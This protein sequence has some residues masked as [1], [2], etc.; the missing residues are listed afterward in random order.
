[1]FTKALSG[2]LQLC[3]LASTKKK[4]PQCTDHICT[5]S[6]AGL[7]VPLDLHDLVADPLPPLPH[8][9]NSALNHLDIGE[10]C[11]FDRRSNLSA[12][13]FLSE[14]A[15]PQK[16]V[17]LLGLADDWPAMDWGLPDAFA[18][19]SPSL[20]TVQTIVRAFQWGLE[21]SPQYQTPQVSNCL[22]RSIYLDL[23]KDPEHK[24]VRKMVRC[25]YST[26]RLFRTDFF[27]ACSKVYNKSYARRWLLIASAGSGSCF[28]IDPFNTSA[29][30]T[31]L[32][33][34]K[35]WAM[36]PPD[37]SFPPPGL[38]ARRQVPYTEQFP[39]KA[40]KTKTWGVSSPWGLAEGD[41]GPRHY[42][43]RVLPGLSDGAKPLQCM[44]RRGETLFVPSGWQHQVLNTAPSLAITENFMHHANAE[45]VMG[46][47]AKRPSSSQP[48][49]CMRKIAATLLASS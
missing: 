4:Q 33:G 49:K 45:S 36:Y 39:K 38:H 30:N 27:A 22:A 8:T 12:S 31:V 42:F 43:E 14:Y 3:I 46:E 18:S 25:G 23:N 2:L 7:E 16:P 44:L 10:H 48:R 29:W 17:V 32:S 20:K 19:G 21:R 37:R 47:L 41:G 35:R 26:P 24:Q 13:E 11:D 1:M 28:H 40:R 9:S 5:A 34:S 6:C 15:Q